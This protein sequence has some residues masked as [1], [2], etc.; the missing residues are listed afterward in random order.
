MAMLSM[1]ITLPTIGAVMQASQPPGATTLPA[2]AVMVGMVIGIGVSLVIYL[3]IP[4]A[5][6]M[7]YRSEDVRQTVEYYDP[8]PRWTDGRPLPVLGIS[9]ALALFAAGALMAT[10]QGVLPVFGI[11]LTGP[12]GMGAILGLTC[13][14]ALAAVLIF[15][16]R[17]AGWWMAVLLLVLFQASWTITMLNV[18]LGGIAT[19]T[20]AP[21][22]QARALEESGAWSGTMAIVIS[23]VGSLAALIYLFRVRHYF[24]QPAT[25]NT[26]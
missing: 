26:Q 3:V 10:A 5:F 17:M 7:F 23:L 8:V 24:A 6:V 15:R 1:L 4:A 20:G 25:A 19:A 2:A 11:L 18:G 9:I 16:Q 21:P 12:A 13:L 22:E 14:L